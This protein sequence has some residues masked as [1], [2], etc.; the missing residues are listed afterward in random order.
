MMRSTS[1]VSSSP[2]LSRLQSNIVLNMSPVFMVSEGCAMPFLKAAI[3]G[4]V[5]ETIRLAMR[6]LFEY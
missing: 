1:G 3:G 2:M 6:Y 5:A 4:S